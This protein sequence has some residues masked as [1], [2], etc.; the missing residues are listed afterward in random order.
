MEDG[1]MAHA[2]VIADNKR[3]AWICVKNSVILYVAAGTDLYQFI[4][5]TQDRSEPCTASLCDADL[6]NDLRIRRDPTSLTIN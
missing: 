5:S 4:V 6:P 1:A 3:K 2:A